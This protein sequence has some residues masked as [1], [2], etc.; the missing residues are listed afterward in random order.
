MNGL[1]SLCAMVDLI[2]IMREYF[3]FW[4][5]MELWLKFEGNK[6]NVNF[7]HKGKNF[8]H[9]NWFKMRPTRPETLPKVQ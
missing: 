4:G 7:I 9:L 8:T 5:D 1:D 3:F 6:G 2:S